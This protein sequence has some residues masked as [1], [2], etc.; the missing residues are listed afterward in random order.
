MMR[1]LRKTRDGFAIA[2][3]LPLIVLIEK[4]MR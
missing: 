3:L 2:V 1:L 4:V